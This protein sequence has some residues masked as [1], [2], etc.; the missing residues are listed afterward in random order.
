MNTDLYGLIISKA[1]AILNAIVAIWF[2]KKNDSHCG[3]FMVR[4]QYIL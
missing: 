3:Y 2:L 4:V 1:I